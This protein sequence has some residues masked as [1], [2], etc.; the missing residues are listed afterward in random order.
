MSDGFLFVHCL[1][2]HYFFHIEYCHGSSTTDWI[3]SDWQNQCMPRGMKRRKERK[4][5]RERAKLNSK[6][7]SRQLNKSF[8]NLIVPL[9]SARW[10]KYTI[11]EWPHYYIALYA[12]CG[13]LSVVVEEKKRTCF[14]LSWQIYTLLLLGHRILF[15][16]SKWSFQLLFLL[17]LLL[18]ATYNLIKY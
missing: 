1:H 10:I 8:Q 16:N 15:L 6:L 4:R 2:R 11:Y 18:L 5:K 7:N 14:F 13:I 17:L 12:A 3:G 9:N